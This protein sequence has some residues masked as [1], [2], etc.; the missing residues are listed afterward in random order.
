MNSKRAAR[1]LKGGEQG[2]VFLRVGSKSGVC[3]VRDL[4]HVC[5]GTAWADKGEDGRIFAEKGRETMAREC[6]HGII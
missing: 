3:M 1:Y 5:E 6:V 4:G 2:R